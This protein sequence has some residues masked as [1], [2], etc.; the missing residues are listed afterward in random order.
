[1]LLQLWKIVTSPVSAD[2]KGKQ[3]NTITPMTRIMKIWWKAK[4]NR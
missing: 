4:L 2:A 3:R 1:M